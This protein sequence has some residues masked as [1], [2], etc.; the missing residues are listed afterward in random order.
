M[1]KKRKLRYLIGFLVII[2]ALLYLLS[3]NFRSSLQYY[4]TVT[5]LKAMEKSPDGRILKVAGKVSDIQREELE[6]TWIYRFKLT[7]GD[8]SIDISYKGFVPDTFKE[9]ADA[10]VT[11]SIAKDGTFEATHILA[12]CA[13]KYEAKLGEEPAANYNQQQ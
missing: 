3:N 8:E 4:V 13:S 12:K 9:H 1:I 7:E 5:E 10:V 11:G 6:T 2:G